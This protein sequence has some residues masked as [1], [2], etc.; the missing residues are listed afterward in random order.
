VNSICLLAVV[1]VLAKNEEEKCICRKTGVRNNTTAQISVCQ[2]W[3][4]N[5]YN[6]T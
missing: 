1:K 6:V 5:L 3:I 4:G 2:G